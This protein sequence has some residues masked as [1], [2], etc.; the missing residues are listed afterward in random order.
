M[1]EMGG[2]GEGGTGTEIDVALIYNIHDIFSLAPIMQGVNI[3]FLGSE[4]RFHIFK[5]HV[6]SLAHLL[7]GS[8]EGLKQ[9]AVIVGVR[10]VQ[11]SQN[12]LQ[13]H[14]SVNMMLRQLR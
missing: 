5:F 2:G 4:K 12:P 10:S 11:H 1:E 9:I 7:Y 6:L 13:P 14:P 3:S 8:K